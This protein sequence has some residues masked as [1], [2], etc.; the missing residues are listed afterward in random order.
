MS[1]GTNITGTKIDVTDLSPS[2]TYYFRVMAVNTAG[3]SAA[4]SVVSGKTSAAS[5]SLKVHFLV[6]SYANWTTPYVYYW[7]SNGAAATNGWPGER[8]TSEGSNWWVFTITGATTSNVIFNTGSSSA[9]TVD[10]SRTG[11]GWFKPTGTS[12]GKVT[13]T[14]YSTKP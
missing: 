9:Q 5:T 8:M 12:N 4:S 11:E 13:G 6:N 10:L 3:T 14:W 1:A 2:T 7:G